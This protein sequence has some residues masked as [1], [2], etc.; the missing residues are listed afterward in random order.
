MG[1]LYMK[2]RVLFVY[3]V[4]YGEPAWE[5]NKLYALAM[6][7][8]GVESAFLANGIIEAGDGSIPVHPYSFHDFRL[9]AAT[10]KFILDFAPDVIHLCS[11]RFLALRVALEAMIISN[12]ELVVK[13][14]DEEIFIATQDYITVSPKRAFEYGITS[15]LTPERLEKLF[16]NAAWPFMMKE[17]LG[18]PSMMLAEPVS[19]GIINHLASGLIGIWDNVA[20]EL[21]KT[22]CKPAWTMP[23][24]LDLGRIKTGPPDRDEIKNAAESLRI[25]ADKKILMFSGKYYPLIFDFDLLLHTLS[26]PVLKNDKSWHFCVTGDNPR[27]ERHY[28]IIKEAGIEDRI[29]WL[30]KLSNEQ[31]DLAQR[32]T[33][34]AVSPGLIN[35]YNRVRLPQKNVMYMAYG[36]PMLTYSCGFGESLTDGENAL[37]VG[38]DSPSVWAEKLSAL[39]QDTSLQNKLGV[40]ARKFAEKRFD[41]NVIAGGLAGFY[42]SI[43]ERRKDDRSLMGDSGQGRNLDSAGRKI[44]EN[45]AFARCRRL[46]VF[47]AGKHTVRLLNSKWRDLL[48][49]KELRIVDDTPKAAELDG[50]KIISFEELKKWKPDGI[51]LST[52]TFEDQMQNRCLEEF[53][54]GPVIFRIYTP[55][56]V[57]YPE[58]YHIEKLAGKIHDPA[59]ADGECLSIC[60]AM[61]ELL[62]GRTIS[63]RWNDT[64]I[65]ATDVKMSSGAEKRIS[66]A[67]VKEKRVLLVEVSCGILKFAKYLNDLVELDRADAFV[68]SAKDGDRKMLQMVWEEFGSSCQDYA[69]SSWNPMKNI[70][71]ALRRM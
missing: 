20:A 1:E 17:W 52:D 32:R 2:T 33:D 25:P 45:D 27:V 43:R 36:K 11:P 67:G 49:S 57:I 7:R 35:E 12:A 41:C 54:N 8:H 70:G 26:M 5:L 42:H 10:K 56:H 64:G 13:H 31:L 15:M 3:V 66:G 19:F 29:T 6:R 58:I 53:R 37:L 4:P 14:E 68:I 18:K 47:G 60:S 46:A 16:E 34:I 51:L 48:R 40:N 59:S 55:R 21:A 30:G 50:V 22:Y 9:D 44:F 65:V 38:V 71:F 23:P 61:S 69:V 63:E 28:K 39:I 62:K 24:T